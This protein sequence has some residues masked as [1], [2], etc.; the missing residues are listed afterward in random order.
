[1]TDSLR[2]ALFGGTFD[3]PHRGH[4][5]I[6][7][8]AADHFALDTVFFAPAGRQPLKPAHA[9]TPFADRLTLAALACGEDPRFA[10]SNL[11]APRADGIPTYTVR[12]LGLLRE[13]M[14][15]ATV[16]NLVGADSFQTLAHWQEPERCLALAEWIV[17]SRPGHPLADPAGMTL[18][19]A[20]RDR[21]H[22]LDS[23]HEDVSATDL[24]RRLEAG[25]PCTELLPAT[26]AHRIAAQHLYRR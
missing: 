21:I 23:V 24:R 6:A 9:V 18:T 14:P 2:I 16:F 5:A 17:V 15:R 19:E 25:E 22:L 11:D 8:A 1:M 4:I 26:V 13:L 3:P 7:R 10:V 12:T 20:Q